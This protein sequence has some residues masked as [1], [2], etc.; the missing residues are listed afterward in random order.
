MNYEGT[1]KVNV[2]SIHKEYCELGMS[3]YSKYRHL[4]LWLTRFVEDPGQVRQINELEKLKFWDELGWCAVA[5]ADM[6]AAD[7]SCTAPKAISQKTPVQRR[8]PEGIS[9]ETPAQRRDIKRGTR[10]LVHLADIVYVADL[11]CA[12]VEAMEII[13]QN[14]TKRGTDANLASTSL[15]SRAPGASR[16]TAPTGM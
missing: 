11:N 15:S 7:S 12:A 9:L 4:V 16:S 1:T 8:A 2:Q 3:L 6:C 14:D 13:S 5:V 10:T